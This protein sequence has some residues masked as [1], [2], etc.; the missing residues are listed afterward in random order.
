MT[1]AAPLQSAKRVAFVSG[2]ARGI[3]LAIAERLARDACHV[4]M[5]DLNGDSVSASAQ[6]L[7][8]AGLSVTP[9]SLD[10]RDRKAVSA[11]FDTLPRLDVAVNNAAIFSDKDFF[12][13]TEEDFRSTYEVNVVG[14]FIV[15]QEAA[16][17]MGDG[18]RIINIGSRSYLGGRN[19]AHYIASKG[20]VASLTRGM[21]IDLASK[22]IY[23]NAVAPGVIETDMF[24]SVSPERRAEML[25]LQLTGKFGQPADIANAVGFLA[26]A[27]TE[28]ITGQ[29]LHVDGGKS[30]G[31][32]MS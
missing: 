8:A 31:G 21:A 17:R 11:L 24:H 27:T 30:L 25:K 32:P 18:G 7:Q 10:V 20:A 12:A 28:Y 1:A 22:G 5:A 29:V 4:V 14:L 16:R 6:K 19:H 9:V 26:A 13:L 15:A 23:V 3:G 2:A